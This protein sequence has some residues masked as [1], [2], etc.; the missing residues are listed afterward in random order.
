MFNIKYELSFSFWMKK[1]FQLKFEKL[2]F[3]VPV[4]TEFHRVQPVV[5]QIQISPMMLTTNELGSEE[6]AQWHPPPIDM[7]L[8]MKT[9]KGI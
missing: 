3:E 2:F 5:E 7:I 6:F 1:Y 9:G 8:K 4:S